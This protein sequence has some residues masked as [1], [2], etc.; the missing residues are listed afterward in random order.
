MVTGGYNELPGIYGVRRGY[1][2]IKRVRGVYK[3]LPIITR[4]Y[5]GLQGVE[6]DTRRLQG[7]T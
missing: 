7:V 3:A 6:G 4:G 1:R 5:R 2:G